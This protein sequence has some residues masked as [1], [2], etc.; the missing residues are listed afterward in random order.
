[1]NTQVTRKALSAAKRLTPAVLFAAVAIVVFLTQSKVLSASERKDTTENYSVNAIRVDGVISDIKIS[2]WDKDDVQLRVLND[3]P[4]QPAFSAR[5]ENNVLIIEQQAGASS[6][7]SV[8]VIT[9]GDGARSEVNIGG[10]GIVI[11]QNGVQINSTSGEDS[12]SSSLE[13]MLPATT[14]VDLN[15]FGGNAMIEHLQSSLRIDGNG[16][17]EVA[18]LHG[19]SVASL[20]NSSIEIEHVSGD[21]QFEL[22][23]NTAINIGAGAIGELTVVAAGN[24]GA[25]IDAQAE[26]ARLEASNNA[27][28][29]VTEV[30]DQPE[31]MQQG[32]A[33]IEIGNWR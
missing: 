23:G 3:N 4:E 18:S 32:N 25:Y 33:T 27:S 29:Q 19:A 21:M 22:S 7:T 6:N 13:I 26:S 1:M 20:G 16:T 24:A 30:V 8:T 5:A 17:L 15:R 28:I 31:V 9:T 2:N 11:S 10:D 12:S 14:A